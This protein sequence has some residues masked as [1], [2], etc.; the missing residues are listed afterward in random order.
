AKVTEISASPNRFPAMHTALSF[1]KGLTIQKS[2]Y[3]I[4]SIRM[5]IPAHCM[6]SCRIALFGDVI[7]KLHKSLIIN[8][9]RDEKNWPSGRFFVT[10]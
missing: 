6:I 4:A 9:K 1:K 2:C 10:L 3:F 7:L 5:I 8:K